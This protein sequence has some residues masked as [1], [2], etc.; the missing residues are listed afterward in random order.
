MTDPSHGDPRLDAAAA[1]WGWHPSNWHV[2]SRRRPRWWQFSARRYDREIRETF[3]EFDRDAFWSQPS[4][5]PYEDAGGA[6]I[7]RYKAMLGLPVERL[8][9]CAEVIEDLL[10]QARA[11]EARAEE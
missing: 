5:S 9:I 2:P 11:K 6:M 8:P 10:N 4:Q 1:R 7:R 3:G